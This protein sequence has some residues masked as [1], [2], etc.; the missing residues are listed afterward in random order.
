VSYRNIL[1]QVDETGPSYARAGA[2]ANIARRFGAK[3]TGMFLQSEN[4]PAFIVGDVFSAVTTVQAFIE[5]RD[6]KIASSKAKAREQFAKAAPESEWIEVNGDDDATVL[7][8]TRRFDLSIF[9]QIAPSSFGTHAVYAPTLAMGSGSP[10]LIMPDRG[11][12]PGLGRKV[13]VAWKETR[14]SA[15]AVRDAMPF[16]AA[17]EEV[18]FLAV[19]RSAAEGFDKLQLRY[20]A[21]H[22]CSNIH[23]HVD[24]NDDVS[25][26]T[27][28]QRHAGMVGADLVVQGL[29]GHSRL[30]E[31]VLGGVSRDMLEMLQ[32]PLLVSH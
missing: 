22:G 5:E 6:A 7:A 24:R 12:E 8:A 20:L 23:M 11:F 14:E 25:V 29:Y 28:I 10:F 3:L 17:A 4:I 2:A 26:A 30:R 16:L 27:I 18:H 32:L 13:L 21:A 19:S 31:M 15:R 1:V 9:P